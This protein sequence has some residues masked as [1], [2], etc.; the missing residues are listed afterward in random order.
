MFNIAAH[1]TTGS[2]PSDAR[3]TPASAGLATDPTVPPPSLGLAACDASGRLTFLS[4]ALRE[5]LGHS[6]GSE[7]EAEPSASRHLYRRDGVT[8]L[9]PEHVPLARA[10]H[11][12]VVTDAVI[13][14]RSEE[15][16]PTY[17]RCSAA[18]VTA[19]D[20]SV[21]GAVV[22]VDDVTTDHVGRRNQQRMQDHLVSTLNH[23]LRT[24]LTKLVGHAE[25]LHD[26]RS[27]LPVNVVRSLDKVCEAVDDLSDLADLVS[28]LADLDTPG[29]LTDDLG[30][31]ADP[32][33]DDASEVSE[34]LAPGELRS[35]PKIPVQ[36]VAALDPVR[37]SVA[38]VALAQVA[39]AQAP[40]SKP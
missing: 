7:V 14:H 32:S 27:Q 38:Q 17:L 20:G 9:R 3:C 22:F 24:P 21:S 8:I 12:E 25:R 40:P 10:R 37:V 26:M 13:C 34:P 33:Y 5:L 4:P 16:V 29:R 2:A 15:E 6:F 18:P 39:L 19:P 1:R 35:V 28:C 23:E 30:D 36:L 31:A 11:G